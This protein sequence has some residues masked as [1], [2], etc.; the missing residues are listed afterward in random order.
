MC[1]GMS[2]ACPGNLETCYGHYDYNGCEVPAFCALECP[3]SE[4][5]DR[6]CW[7][8]PDPECGE[9]EIM[10]DMGIDSMVK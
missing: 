5:D 2:P 3:N 4:Y 9:F 1:Y 10:C 6:G 8:A 7:A